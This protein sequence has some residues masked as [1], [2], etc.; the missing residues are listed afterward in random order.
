MNL[1]EVPNSLQFT[2]VHLISMK[3]EGNNIEISLIDHQNKEKVAKITLSN[4]DPKILKASTCFI[5]VEY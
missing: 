2:Q 4:S 5:I 1:H 3:N